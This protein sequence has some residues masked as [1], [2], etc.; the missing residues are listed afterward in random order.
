[1]NETWRTYG[2]LRNAYKILI[3][4]KTSRETEESMGVIREL[5]RK[6]AGKRQGKNNL[7]DLDV[8]GNIIFL[9]LNKQGRR[10]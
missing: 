3:A 10:V 9:I 4:K 5:Y 8:D 7:E 6:M 1:M 2:K